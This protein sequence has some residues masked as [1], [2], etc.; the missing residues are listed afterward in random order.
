MEYQKNNPFLNN[1]N[2]ILKET[3]KIL[4]KFLKERNLFKQF[5]IKQTNV[6]NIIEKIKYS[7]SPTYQDSE[8]I[9]LLNIIYLSIN[10]K[11][12][13]SDKTIN[14]Q[15]LN[16]SFFKNENVKTEINNIISKYIKI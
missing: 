10:E 4:S 8:S 11:D 2:P 12:F 7:Y 5:K 6:S 1:L 13:F 15:S 9:I 14:W 3:Y 16:S